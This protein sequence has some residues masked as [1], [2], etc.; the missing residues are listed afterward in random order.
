MEAERAYMGADASINGG[1]AGKNGG[2]AAAG[3]G[4]ACAPARAWRGRWSGSCPR[5]TAP[6]MSASP[7]Q[8]GAVDP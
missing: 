7:P 4:H 5:D 2:S 8:M 6:E 1:S 3:R